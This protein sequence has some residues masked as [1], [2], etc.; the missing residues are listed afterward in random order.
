MTT[1][2]RLERLAVA[3]DTPDW[4]EF[5]ELAATFGPH[6][7]VLKVGLEAY[8]RWGA[9][10][11]A[12]A[13]RHGAAYARAAFQSRVV[14]TPAGSSPISSPASRPSFSLL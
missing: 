9:S 4:A 5:V 8:T 11:V 1:K 14:T 13:S 6:V 12:E 10:A 2:I 7:G 3:L